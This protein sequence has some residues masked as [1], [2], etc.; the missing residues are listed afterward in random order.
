[1]HAE[2][3]QA[4]LERQLKCKYWSEESDEAHRSVP[5]S[6][7]DPLQLKLGFSHLS[8]FSQSAERVARAAPNGVKKGATFLLVFRCL[9]HTHSS[10]K[11]FNGVQ[12][13]H[14]HSKKH[15]PQKIFLL[16]IDSGSP[17][18]GLKDD[19]D[20][21]GELSWAHRERT[22]S[23]RICSN[24]WPC[25]TLACILRMLSASVPFPSGWIE[26]QVY[27]PLNSL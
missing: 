24:S 20:S 22:L 11:A 23:R 21:R 26:K 2:E 27:A 6:C 19:A 15:K 16:T 7:L 8:I 13:G 14:V 12:K 10:R 3:R 4:R 18:A 9:N 1:M 17:P 5:T 25:K